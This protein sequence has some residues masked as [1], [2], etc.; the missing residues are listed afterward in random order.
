ME[1]RRKEDVDVRVL[2]ER[3]NNWMESTENY[4]KTLC[5]KLDIITDKMNNLPC[6]VRIEGTK[7]IQFQLKA[8][9]A[10]TGGM[11]LAIISEWIQWK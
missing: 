11:V 9:W 7:N 4:R 6:K 2:T 10:V 3:V 5:H 1:E 8:L